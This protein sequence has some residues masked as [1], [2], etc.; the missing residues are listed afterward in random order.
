[1][2]PR[3][4]LT[5]FGLI[6]VAELS[7][8]TAYT[9][10]LLATRRRALPVLFGACSAFAVQGL[11]AL[12]LGSVL[13]LLPPQIIRWSAAA[14][15][16]AFGAFLLLHAE[17][18]PGGEPDAVSHRKVFAEAFTLVFLAELGDA[19][20]LGTAALVARLHARWSVFAGSTSALCCVA[21]LAV[22][23]GS[24]AGARLPKRGLRRL[25]GALFILFAA[26]SLLLF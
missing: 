19:T 21:A 6:F 15:L 4:L 14:L 12:A 9:V 23:V 20:Q 16:F 1:M 10:L 5:T 8:K 3:A 2:D 26:G 11:V 25:A 22:T 24:R 7:D 13:A 18:Q 17:P